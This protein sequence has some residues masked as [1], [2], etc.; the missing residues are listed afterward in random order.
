VEGIT[1]GG[2]PRKRCTDEFDEDLKIMRRET[3]GMEEDFI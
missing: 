1:K 3:E 2:G